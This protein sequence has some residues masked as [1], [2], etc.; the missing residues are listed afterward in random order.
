MKK[1]MKYYKSAKGKSSYKK[2]LKADVKRSTSKAGPRKR[3]KI[4]PERTTTT[5]QNVLLAP[6][7]TGVERV[8]VAA[9]LRLRRD[10]LLDV[11]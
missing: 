2:K 1:T 4:L 11:I 7:R 10:R 6:L 8:R 3:A 9:S 5:Q